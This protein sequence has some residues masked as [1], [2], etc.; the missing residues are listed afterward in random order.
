MA[1]ASCVA[2]AHGLHTVLPLPRRVRRCGA[3]CAASPGPSSHNPLGGGAGPGN[4]S[5]SGSRLEQRLEKVTSTGRWGRGAA[6]GVEGDSSAEGVATSVLDDAL[7]AAPPGGAGPWAAWQRVF[8]TD[9]E[10][11]RVVAG[12]EVRVRP[13]SYPAFYIEGLSMPPPLPPRH[14]TTPR[15]AHLATRPASLSRYRGAGTRRRCA[16][17]AR[18]WLCG[19]A[20]TS[21][22]SGPVLGGANT[23]SSSVLRRATTPQL[24][25]TCCHVT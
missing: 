16:T 1:T 19:R 10:T 7:D 25:S 15:L 21:P 4:S 20:R 2:A 8:E 17:A 3:K 5:L 6:D 13:R 18:R 24:L 9:E 11:E 12:L 14:K 23:P 22:C